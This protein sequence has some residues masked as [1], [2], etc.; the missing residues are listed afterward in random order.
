LRWI[1]NQLAWETEGAAAPEFELT[2][3][4]RAPYSEH[5]SPILTFEYVV[6]TI[7]QR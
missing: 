1:E 6:K 4:R 3:E 7:T 2:Q 5:I